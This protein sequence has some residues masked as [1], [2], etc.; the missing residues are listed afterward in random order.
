MC[1]SHIGGAGPPLAAPPRCET[2]PELVSILVF[3]CDFVLMYNF[4][5]FNLPE[6]PRFVYRFLVVFC[7]ELFLSGI[8]LG[9]GVIMSSC[10]PSEENPLADS[11]NP[12][13]RE[14]RMHLKE[15]SLK[16][17]ELQIKDV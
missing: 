11:I 12:Y 2:T 17:G 8:A 6:S 14:L 10:Y 16:Y 5:L 3:S 9:F 4:C 15:L 13:M 1:F 7:F